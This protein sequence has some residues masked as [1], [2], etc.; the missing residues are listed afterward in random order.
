MVMTGRGGLV[1]QV[2]GE[3]VKAA[4]IARRLTQQELAEAAGTT[5]MQVHRH[6]HQLQKATMKIL[7]S[8]A[9]V[10]GVDVETLIAQ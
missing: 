9:E 2:D 10:L 1:V 8:Y 4:R 3:A 5:S 7:R 6:E